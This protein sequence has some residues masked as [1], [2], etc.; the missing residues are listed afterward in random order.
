MIFFPSMVNVSNYM[1]PLMDSHLWHILEELTFSAFLL[2][3]ILL[4]W[5][6]ASRSQDTILSMN[7]IFMVTMSSCFISY[8]LAVPFYLLVEKPFRNFMDLI[9]FPKSTIFKRKKDVD[10]DEDE[11]E[12]EETE[13]G[14][15]NNR[16]G[17]DNSDN[18]NDEKM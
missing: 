10:D 12:E 5:F 15:S 18:E 3:Y 8:L 13:E 6:F 7:Y 4:A 17:P 16:D 9:L 14:D 11:E 1:R 2:H